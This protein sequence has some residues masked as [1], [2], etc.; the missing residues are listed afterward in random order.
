MPCYG[1]FHPAL[2]IPAAAVLAVGLLAALIRLAIYPSTLTSWL[3]W[4]PMMAAPIL[5][6]ILADPRLVSARRMRRLLPTVRVEVIDE[7]PR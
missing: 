1:R 2:H 6:C 7:V 5:G 3:L 4:L